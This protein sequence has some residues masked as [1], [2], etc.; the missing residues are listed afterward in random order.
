MRMQPVPVSDAAEAASNTVTAMGTIEAVDVNGRTLTVKHGRIEALG[1][2][3]MTM[4]MPVADAVDIG[5]AQPGDRIHF[6]L[7]QDED[8]SYQIGSVQV[9]DNDTA[10]PGTRH[11]N[12]GNDR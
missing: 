8:G 6:T 11:S 2:P 10:E 5:S 12:T 3:A 4:E 7:I 1:W 9:L